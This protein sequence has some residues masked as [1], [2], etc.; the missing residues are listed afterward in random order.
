MR[1]KPIL[2]QSK[3]KN[4]TPVDMLIPREFLYNMIMEEIFIINDERQKDSLFIT[5]VNKIKSLI[6]KKGK[7]DKE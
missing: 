1:R 5:A 4:K 6:N 7:E 2:N 3:N